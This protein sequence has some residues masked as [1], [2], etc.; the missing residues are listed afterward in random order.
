MNTIKKLNYVF[1]R[2]QKFQVVLLIFIIL[3]GT[4]FEFVGITAVLPLINAFIAPEEMLQNE[5]VKML[6]EWFNFK[7]TT[8]FISFL[9][10][11]VILVYVVKN[12]YII[13]MQWVQY[14][15]IYNGQRRMAYR[16]LTHYMNQS[17]LF[18]TAHNSSALLRNV[19][20]DT[21]QLFSCIQAAIQLL[22]EVSVCAVMFVVLLLADPIITFVVAITL[23]GFMLIFVKIMNKRMV[24]YGH[25]SRECS[26]DTNRWILQAFGGIKET[27]ILERKN[28]FVRKYDGYS[29]KLMD[30]RRK[31]Q[32]LSSLPHPI[33]EMTCIGGLLIAVLIK[34][35]MN[36]DMQEFI[37]TLTLFAVAAFR[38]LPC[39]NRLSKNFATFSYSKASVDAVY[40]DLKLCEEHEKRLDEK[41]ELNESV[42]LEKEITVK[43]VTFRYPTIDANVLQDV[44]VCIPK[45]KSVAFIGPS[46]AGKT[47]LAD[48]I[49]G[50]L[51]PQ[52]GSVLVDGVDV[53][54]NMKNW[55]K[56]IGY[57]PQ[58]IFLCDDTLK[59]NIA[60][61]V[62]AKDVDEAR[63]WK[64][65]EEAQLKDFIDTLENG[66]ETVVGERGTRLSGGQRQR[67]GIARALYNNPEFL[68]LDEATSALD[69]ETEKAVM[70]SIDSLSKTKTL[71]II[72]H[73][74]TTIKNCDYIYEI[75]EQKA[76]LLTK[77]E[78][79]SRLKNLTDF[80]EEES[81]E[82]TS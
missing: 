35:N 66:I 11:G 75:K 53:Q 76:H 62:R 70:E 74:L 71:L 27:I 3:I 61:G 41:S 48:I 18:H 19:N 42:K 36:T 4:V 65:I 79:Q 29:K 12:L 28:F 67:I 56:K 82:E 10:I 45:N 68:V 24:A 22:T 33:M 72:A 64:A 80:D 47:T 31:Q 2:R 1:E 7:D 46:G 77:E 54:K 38:L 16:L 60:F 52:Q 59:N 78:W 40:D 17:Y 63:V 8:Q 26:K 51:E 15:F 9:T 81:V 44:N 58:N 23:G 34:I 39:F 30:T 25:L 49:L 32:F 13:W 69:N 37:P 55:H 6:Y 43:N 20:T 73:R 14:R 57:I 5:Y 50:V 21:S